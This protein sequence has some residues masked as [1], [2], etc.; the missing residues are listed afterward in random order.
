[1]DPSHD[2]QIFTVSPEGLALS[3]AHYLL[4]RPGV[5]RFAFSLRDVEDPLA[6]QGAR[7]SQ[8]SIRVWCE[9]FGVQ[10]AAK[11]RQDRPA[12]ADKWHIEGDMISIQERNTVFDEPAMQMEMCGKS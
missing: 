3:S 12:P 6:E 10:I 11:V 5:H 2:Q 7:V 9:R 8:E 1:M 4:C